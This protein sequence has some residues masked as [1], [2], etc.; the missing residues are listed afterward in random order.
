MAPESGDGASRSEDLVGG[1][2]EPTVRG[3]AQ[4]RRW[5]GA[6]LVLATVLGAVVVLPR[7]SLH[8]DAP[9]G[10]ARRPTAAPAVPAPPNGGV[11]V[12]WPLRGDLAGD[13]AFVA[14]A[15]R[16]LRRD[17]PAAARPLFAGRLP[18]GSRLLLAGAADSSVSVLHIAARHT[19]VTGVVGD[20]AA[21]SDPAQALGWATLGRD[22]RTY[23]IVL[24]APRPMR[25]QLSPGVTFDQAGAPHRRWRTES[26]ADGVVVADL[27]SPT[28]PS[29]AVSSVQPDLFVAPGL[30]PVA[31][32][33]RTPAASVEVAGTDAPA[34]AG[35]RPAN[36]R[37]GLSA[38]TADL[39]DLGRT[40]QRVVWSGVPW[41]Q[42]HFAIVLIRR[43]DGVR[44]QALVGEQ[45]GG[46]FPAG[47][48]AL[49]RSDPDGLPWLLEPFSPQDPTL[50]LCPTGPGSVVYRRGER[51][52]RLHVRADGVVSLVD[53]GSAPPS[54]AGARVTLY[55]PQGT[56]LLSTVLPRTGFDNPLARQPR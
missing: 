31:G 22:G 4:R 38:E 15:L 11:W 5:R 9:P 12:G 19:F 53:P 33:S 32:R 6:A 36:L 27:G 42:R 45:D 14:A 17:R 23:A 43:T 13:P 21:L 40:A 56:R 28:D 49:A 39:L 7:L 52:T 1:R 35:P 10:A 50:L 3:L 41:A 46:W 20:A 16:R 48:R 44:L 30:I 2:P 29:V 34:Y 47:V 18:D 24:G 25:V 54:T 37:A 26:T 51:R 8:A 55:D